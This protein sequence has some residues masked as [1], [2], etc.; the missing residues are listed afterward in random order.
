MEYTFLGHGFEMD[1]IISHRNE[2]YLFTLKG[3]STFKLQFACT[4]HG[5]S[6]IDN[7]DY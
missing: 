3:S 4:N 5:F 7:L 1:L 6:G 2:G